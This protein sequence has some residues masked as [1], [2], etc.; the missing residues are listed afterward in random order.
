MTVP[1]EKDA[2]FRA[3]VRHKDGGLRAQHEG[4]DRAKLVAE[5]E[6]EVE[7]TRAVKGDAGVKGMTITIWVREDVALAR[8][9]ELEADAGMLFNV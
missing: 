8:V 9:E 1:H 3:I 2:K 7:R 4:N 5:C 6:A